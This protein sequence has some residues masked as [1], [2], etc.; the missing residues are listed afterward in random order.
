MA[1][2]T[3][4]YS[5]RAISDVAPNSPSEMVKAKT[6]ATNS[7][8]PDQRQIDGAKRQP[9]RSAQGSGCLV[10]LR[11]DTA[12]GRCQA[13]HHEGE[14]HQG[15]CQRHQRPGITQIKRRLIQG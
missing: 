11:A 4:G 9:R 8:R 15:V 10:Q 5:G 13:A 1:T 7:E 6:A 3:V 2:G 14:S 12:Q